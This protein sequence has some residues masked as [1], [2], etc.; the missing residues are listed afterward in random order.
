M[1]TSDVTGAPTAPPVPRPRARR[2][3]VAS[4]PA[5]HVYVRHLSPE[6]GSGPVRLPDPPPAQAAAS[7]QWWPPVMLDAAWVEAN[8]FDVFHVHFGFDAR[9]PEDLREL[10]A[11]LR[12]RGK[13]LVFTVHDLR[14]P[15]HP[16]RREHDRQL[17]VLVPAA[18][19][20]ITL[21][22][23]A[24][25]E[26]RDRWG[27][28]ALVVPHPHVVPLDVMRRAAAMREVRRRGPRD[29]EFRVGLHVKSLR[30]GMHPHP[31]LPVLVDTL[32]DL[33]GAVLQVN[34]HTDVLS[35]GGTRHDPALTEALHDH[36]ARGE[37]DLRIHDYLDDDGLWDYLASLD[38][39][40]LPYRF[41]THSGWLEACRDLGT[42]VVA[43]SCGYFADQ[44][45]V[46]TYGHDERHLDADSLAAAVRR[47]YAGHVA[48]TPSVEERR[49]QRAQVAAAHARVYAALAEGAPGVGR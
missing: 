8:D 16:D 1:T 13:P 4:V 32:R 26:I 36:A 19:A 30:A 25:A 21:T 20:L 31:L 42:A 29:R 48:P 18:D 39:S 37:V 22:R 27:R 9:S 24:A 33:P 38:V 40:V 46:L 35:P 47:A 12:R 11:A 17:D 34:G 3:V 7:Q 6:D 44:A 49:I 10:V 2:L 28:D 14:N 15:H 5:D 43:P 23:G 41:G 45:P